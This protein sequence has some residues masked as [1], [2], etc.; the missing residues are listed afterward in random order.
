MKGGHW[1]R[2]SLG[3][4]S[5]LSHWMLTDGITQAPR[6]TINYNST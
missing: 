6:I 3:S 4:V 5:S 1:I 2:M